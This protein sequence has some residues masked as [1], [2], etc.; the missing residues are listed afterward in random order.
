MANDRAPGTL[1]LALGLIADAGPV[2][3]GQLRQA[4]REHAGPA[5]SASGHAPDAERQEVQVASSVHYL[6]LAGLVRAVRRATYVATD[7]GVAWHREHGDAFGLAELRPRIEARGGGGGFG[8]DVGYID[9]LPDTMEGGSAIFT[10][11]PFHEELAPTLLGY[12]DRQEELISFLESLRARD[13]II[14]PLLDMLEDGS[15]RI[16][17][18]LDP[19]TFIG[20]MHRGIGFEQR[21]AIA[22][23]MKDHFALGAAVPSDFLG[24]PRQNNMASWFI[25]YSKSRGEDD[26]ATLWDVLAKAL[27]NDPWSDPTFVPILDRGFALPRVRRKLAMGLYWVRP[28]TFVSL[29][30]P[31]RVE[32]GLTM[33]STHITAAE[34]EAVL[35]KLAERGTNPVLLSLDAWLA[36]QHP[37]APA[38]HPGGE[39]DPIAPSGD[40]QH[41]LVGAYWDGETGAESQVERFVRDGIWEN[42]YEDKYLDEVRSIRPGDRIAIKSTFTQRKGLPFDARGRTVSVMRIHTTGTVTGNPGDGHRIEVDWDPEST[43]RDWYFFTD[44]STIRRV[45]TDASYHRVEHSHRLIDFVWNGAAQDLEWYAKESFDGPDRI[46]DPAGDELEGGVTVGSPYGIEDMLAEGV[47]LNEE[48]LEELVDLIRTKRAVIL[49][50]PPGVGKTFLAWR[51]AYG[52]MN[53][54]D[55]DRVAIVQFHQSTSYEDFVRGFRPKPEGVGFEL[56]DGV[57]VTF[58]ER[59]QKDPDRPYVF[60]IDEINRG[61]LSQIFGELLMLIEGDKRTKRYAVPLTYRHKGE[62]SFHVPANVHVLGLMNVADRSLAMVDYALRRRFAFAELHPQFDGR[63]Y[64][65]W[66]EQR[67]MR[68]QLTQTIIN[69]MTRLNEVITAD[70]LLGRNYRV[71]HSYFCPRGDD[72]SELDRRWYERVIRTEIAPL[73]REYWFDSPA[74]ARQEED[75]LLAP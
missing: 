17:D 62:G 66:L 43:P 23:A 45:R 61:N 72:F 36:S 1:P 4:V 7:D 68:P 30:Q 14:T 53:Q 46:E 64:A 39:A 71:G 5:A 50:G 22:S 9:D 12:R 70:P 55:D 13:L 67:G 54:R 33:S 49:Q 35:R 28:R 56:Q 52:V 42:G 63:T 59:A 15:R 29:D 19:F 26:V 6:V 25:Q 37:V 75:A 57:F 27:L 34:Y 21:V 24:V 40:R 3:L 48:E 8:A 10:W 16:L 47:F 18:Q 2:T 73:L 38:E 65:A 20:T 60:I 11:I 58:C 41:W 31:M 51:L 74:R 44:W 69:R 32:L